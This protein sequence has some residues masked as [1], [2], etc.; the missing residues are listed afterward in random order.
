MELTL[1]AAA[2]FLALLANVNLVDAVNATTA[3]A[4]VNAGSSTSDLF[5]PTGSM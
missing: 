5:P 2:A 4:S 3:T 1:T